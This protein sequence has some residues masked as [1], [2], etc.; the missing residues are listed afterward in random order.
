MS[1]PRLFFRSSLA[2]IAL[3]RPYSSSGPPPRP[4]P[5]AAA[6]KPVSPHISIYKDFGRPFAKVFL[7]AVFVYQALY[8]TWIK[9]EKDEERQTKSGMAC[10][11]TR[12]DRVLIQRGGG[13]AEIAV[14]EE[15]VMKLANSKASS[16]LK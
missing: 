12:G 2:H 9:M 8:W 6:Q 7:M 4:P 15:E 14:L 5:S 3:R 1:P 16:T 10:P 11:L 13:I